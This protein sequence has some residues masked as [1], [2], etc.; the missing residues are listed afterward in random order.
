MNYNG[1]EYEKG[2]YIGRVLGTAVNDP[3]SQIPPGF[4]PHQGR[5]GKEANDTVH[6]PDVPGQVPYMII[7]I[8]IKTM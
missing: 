7:S 5:E 8:V 2:H 4:P 3:R 6:L 1:K